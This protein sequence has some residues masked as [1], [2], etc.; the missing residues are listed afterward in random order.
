[1]SLT[2]V[3]PCVT[4][5]MNAGYY[6]QN[7]ITDTDSIHK[8]ASDSGASMSDESTQTVDSSVTSGSIADE[9]D[10]YVRGDE[11]ASQYTHEAN[12]TDTPSTSSPRSTRMSRRESGSQSPISSI[13]DDAT[14]EHLKPINKAMGPEQQPNGAERQHLPEPIPSD[15]ID[16]VFARDLP[17]L[18]STVIRAPAR[19]VESLPGKKI[20]DKAANAL[21]IWLQVNQDDLN[22]I[23]Q[24]I[25]LLH[26]A[27]LI[28][29]DVEDGSISRRGRPA[30]HMVFGTPQAINSA[31]YQINKAMIEVLKLGDAQCIEVFTEEMDKL[32]IGQGHDLFW[33]FNIKRPSVEEY[34]SMVDYKTGALFNMLVRLM[35]IKNQSSSPITPDLNRLVVLLGRYFQIRDDYMNLT[36][37][38]YTDQK[39]FCDDLDEGKF[40]LTLIHALENTEEAEYS[41]L[42]H[43]LG[44]RHI[45]N[46]M[47]LAQKHLVLHI[48]KEAGSLEY[49][50]TALR[51]ISQEIEAETDSIEEA[52]G[53]E[54]KPLRALFEVLKV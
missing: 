22:Q 26:N 36:S 11:N 47:S 18:S 54:N 50:V 33:T 25:N 45:A 12:T 48:L 40:S 20:R 23:R 49:T 53:I 4:T 5:G 51:K 10:D 15:R 42:R 13:G 46:G 19:Y 16:S 30:P 9:K 29:D 31:G 17:A 44:Q 3:S 38:E 1:M 28:L 7:D 14:D 37:L 8:T 6:E 32:Y 24:V 52:T 34:I 35:T 27:S 39:G 41:I 21:N 2:C 43:V